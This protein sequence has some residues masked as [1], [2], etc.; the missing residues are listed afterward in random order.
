M[1]FFDTYN[2]ASTGATR[3]VNNEILTIKELSEFLKVNERTIYRLANKGDI[4][5]FKVGNSWRFERS[6]IVQWMGD[7]AQRTS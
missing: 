6:K 1:Y 4:P 7:Q 3:L 2:S 5:A